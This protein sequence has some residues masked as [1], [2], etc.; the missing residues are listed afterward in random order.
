MLSALPAAGIAL[1]G[2]GGGSLLNGGGN[3]GGGG[4]GGPL[5]VQQRAAVLQK[6]G[7]F[8]AGLKKAMPP[9]QAA[10][11]MADYLKK[12]PEFE[13]AGADGEGNAWGRFTD[14]RLAIFVNNDLPGTGK[15]EDLTA[16]RSRSATRSEDQPSNIPVGDAYICDTLGP[17]FGNKGYDV[18][19]LT[20]ARY[21]HPHFR[22]T[23]DELK[24]LSN[25][26]VFFYDG[27][28]GYGGLRDKSTEFS[29]WTGTDFSGDN[30]MKYADDLKAH[31]LVYM[32]A[33]YDEDAAGKEDL[34][35]RYAFT[36][37]FV[38]K[39]MSFGQNS[40]VWISACSS[41]SN[42]VFV[43]SF[44]ARGASV[45][46]GF[47]KPITADKARTAAVVFF[48][49]VTGDNQLTDIVEDPRQR[50]FDWKS[51]LAWMQSKQYDYG[52]AAGTSRLIFT[53]QS[54]NSNP[55]GPLAPSIAFMW[56]HEYE[57]KLYIYGIFGDNPG[58]D[59]QVTIGGAPAQVQEWAYDG[60][61]KMDRI[62]CKLPYE[63]AGSAG[64]V[65]VVVREHDSNVRQL[66]RYNGK[67]TLTHDTGDGRKY[68]IKHNLRFRVDLQSLRMKPGEKPVF[69]P[70]NPQRIFADD[71][72]DADFEASGS[73]GTPDGGRIAWSGKDTLL[74]NINGSENPRGFIASIRFDPEDRKAHLTLSGG[75]KDGLIQTITDKNGNTTTQITSVI[76]GL[77]ELDG[78]DTDDPHPYVT[79][80]AEINL[81]PDFSIPKG[82]TTAKKVFAYYSAA[83]P[84][85]DTVK[86]EWDPISCEFPPKPDAARSVKSTGRAVRR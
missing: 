48:D 66:S 86:V 53:T 49:R 80:Y 15:A 33:K 6:T 26:G 2:C 77:D 52:D 62:I 44:L 73:T 16:L 5:T 19:T 17:L 21:Y 59:G 22:R 82:S 65:K 20:G 76:F 75:V 12:Q 51:I 37:Q 58:S 74:N 35:W 85:L 61:T 11:Q 71:K 9:L 55:V 46:A 24:T 45:Y 47:P 50:P 34:R 8:F 72:S 81:G 54:G 84:M 40:L 36:S 38:M 60:Q 32:Y 25:A 29:V 69:T 70:M 1:A 23:V 3:G 31:R 30:D 43:S 41:S 63:G 13:D 7:G 64:D 10:Q 39:Y 67:V 57:E 68:T 79:P 18:E 83:A 42:N 4:G 27:H 28:G 78:K 56:A 14:D